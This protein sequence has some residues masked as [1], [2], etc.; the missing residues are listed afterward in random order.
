ME[1][2]IIC[3]EEQESFIFFHCKHKVCNVCFPL[4]VSNTNRCPLCNKRIILEMAEVE[5][6]VQPIL[7]PQYIHCLDVCRIYI[8]VFGCVCILL[9]ILSCAPIRYS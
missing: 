6:I 3:F 8:I 2:C 4:L 7:L 9:Y 5:V 1:E